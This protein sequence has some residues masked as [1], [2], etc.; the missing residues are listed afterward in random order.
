MT[1]T[2]GPTRRVLLLAILCLAAGSPLAAKYFS[3]VALQDHWRRVDRVLAWPAPVRLWQGEPLV[4]PRGVNR[5]G[6]WLFVTDPGDRRDPVAKPARIVR[7]RLVGG[8]PVNPVV[9]FSR[10]GFLHSAKWAVP[11]EIGGSPHLVVADQGEELADGT[12]TGVGGKVFVL[13]VLAGGIAGKPR[14][15]WEGSPMVCPTGVARVGEYLYVSDPC[16]GPRRTR[17]GVPDHPY[18]SSALFALRVSGGEKP[19]LVHHGWPFTSLIGVCG[20]IPGELSV[21]DT[22]SGRL[23]RS[24][25][26][27]RPDFAP[28]AASDHWVLEILDP[29]APALGPPVR[30]PFTEDGPV[31][32]R[33]VNL[34]PDVVIT[35]DSGP[36]NV[37]LDPF[38]GGAPA[39]VI[40]VT[41][42][43]L[44]PDATLTFTTRSDVLSTYICIEV[45][46]TPRS[47]P[48]EPSNVRPRRVDLRKDPRQ[49]S[50]L[51][52]NKWRVAKPRPAVAAATA[53]GGAA[54]SVDT[55]YDV[56]TLDSAPGH[57]AV[58][59]FPHTG[60]TPV[61]IAKGA[62]LVRPLASQFNAAADTLWITDQAT[63][64]LY[65]IPFP[66]PKIFDALFP[67]R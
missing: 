65:A 18:V 36:D 61:A 40:H 38:A 20:A 49:P 19:L 27:G 51:V 44:G 35:L 64:S 11:V 46:L 42:D 28:P 8:V 57:A 39:E 4:A 43:Q 67:E 14:V 22:D 52:D 24:G 12:F 21:I 50:Q 2:G 29:A 45:S 58:W 54:A 56:N 59:I 9:F 13:P 30:T 66:G 34:P 37:I 62:P 32:L 25:A 33:F 6:R 41:A 17:S 48:L 10:P 60:G 7:F 5:L 26:G 31:T 16:A 63:G 55:V 1:A 47:V 53:G 15:L 23:D 3:V